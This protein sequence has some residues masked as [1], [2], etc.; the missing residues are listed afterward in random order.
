MRAGEKLPFIIAIGYPNIASETF[1]ARIGRKLLHLNK[2]DLRD[3]IEA[4]IDINIIKTDFPLLYNGIKAIACAPSS[5]NKQPVKLIYRDNRISAITK[6]NSNSDLI[7]LGIALYNFQYVYPGFWDWGNP[8]NF[9][10]EE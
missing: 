9:I 4:D 10:A 1:V 8:A 7:D 2:R 3:F 5:M 6:T